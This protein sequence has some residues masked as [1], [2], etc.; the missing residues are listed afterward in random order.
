G[1]H[2]LLARALAAVGVGDVVEVRGTDRA[3]DVHLRGW[4][5]AHG[6]RAVWPDGPAAGWVGRVERGAAELGR[7]KDAQRAGEAD[8]Q[9]PGA[10]VDHPL[11]TWGLAGRSARIE[12]GSPPFA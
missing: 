10:V 11:P 1:G 12:A 2:L 9:R 4:C 3:L 5:R 6:H 8:A 7:W